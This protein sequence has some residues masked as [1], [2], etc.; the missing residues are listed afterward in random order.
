MKKLFSVLLAAIIMLSVTLTAGAA[1]LSPGLLVLSGDDP[2]V[3]SGIVGEPVAF[4][5]KDFCR[6]AGISSYDDITVTALPPASEGKLSVAGEA[7]SENDKISY[8]NTDRLVFSPAEGVTESTFCFS[9]GDICEAKCVFK[10]S[11]K[12]NYAPTAS[13]SLTAI[14]TF[15][16]MSVNG[17]M[18]ASD[19][20][21]D[22]LTYEITE[23]PANGTLTYDKNNGSFTYTA[24]ATGHDSFTFTVKDPYGNYSD[25]A[26][27]DI[28]VSSNTTGISF[29]DMKNNG[30]YAAAIH[31]IDD[32]YMTA[33]E[34]DGEV[35]FEPSS[36]VTRL[37][38]L[39]SAMNVLGAGNLPEVSSTD[40]ADDG[41]I[42]DNAKSYVYSACKLGI[43][44]GSE[45]S[46]G[47][48]YFHP[49][50]AITRAEAAVILNN[51]VGY[52]AA[53]DFKFEDNVP[54][55]ASDSVNAMYELGIL[56][57]DNGFVNASQPLTRDD[58][59]Q[60]LHRLK[61]L[62]F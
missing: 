10:L 53:V 18:V 33:T 16:G 7:L 52:S 11:D 1:L 29:T 30:A 13:S 41:E 28:S 47:E 48:R 60:L 59:A 39:V 58:S 6:H 27:V 46:D 15:S 21:R 43:I 22:T 5:A 34:A 51:I 32:G 3:M 44:N 25:E 26:T 12:I 24:S 14:D 17:H 36:T 45:D 9:I 50:D 56:T 42:P 38:F 49:A 31:M 35:Y 2:M 57:P 40:F 20:E 61:R 8:A 4:T 54:A 23:Y 37:D 62:V 19:P 55:W